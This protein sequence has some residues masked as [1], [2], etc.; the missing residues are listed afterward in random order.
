MSN[1]NKAPEVQILSRMTTAILESEKEI[2]F[3]CFLP[4]PEYME[5]YA[6]LNRNTAGEL[7]T[8]EKEISEASSTWAAPRQIRRM[9]NE[10]LLCIME[11]F[12][13]QYIDQEKEHLISIFQKNGPEFFGKSRT[14]IEVAESAP[15]VRVFDLTDVIKRIFDRCLVGA[16]LP[17]RIMKQAIKRTN[18]L[19]G[20]AYES[21]KNINRYYE[22]QDQYSYYA[23][24]QILY[25]ETYE[26]LF[27]LSTTYDFL[28]SLLL[29]SSYELD[30]VKKTAELICRCKSRSTDDIPFVS[31]FL[32]GQES[33]NLNAIRD[34][35]RLLETQCVEFYRQYNEEEDGVKEW[36]IA[37]I[38]S[39]ID[40]IILMY[41]ELKFSKQKYGRRNKLLSE[42]EE[43]LINLLSFFSQQ[44]KKFETYSLQN[45]LERISASESL[46]V[47][48]NSCLA[49]LVMKLYCFNYQGM[50]YK[51]FAYEYAISRLLLKYAYG[52]DQNETSSVVE[53]KE[54]CRGLEK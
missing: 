24:R 33:L 20:A 46:Q 2:F 25:K 13:K 27:S 32:C 42:R 21:M 41:F 40:Q 52:N 14:D 53:E 31:D 51:Q 1:E 5:H 50:Q 7:Q 47:M 37:T 10:W 39:K 48:E 15:G 45:S 4:Y 49:S 38:V 34:K 26:K 17:D 11:E 30:V 54:T 22:G 12:R 28:L 23:L 35:H 18:F 3:Q 36:N 44:I 43:N 8:K 16:D 6:E 9:L 29:K 19:D